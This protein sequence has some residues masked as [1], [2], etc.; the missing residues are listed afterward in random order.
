MTIPKRIGSGAQGMVFLLT[1]KI[2]VKSVF[3]SKSKLL[4][5]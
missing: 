1:K 2:S 5:I 3:F 4:F